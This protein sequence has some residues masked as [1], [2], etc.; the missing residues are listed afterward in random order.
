MTK[1][2]KQYEGWISNQERIKDAMPKFFMTG[3]SPPQELSFMEHIPVFKTKGEKNDWTYNGEDPDF[4]PP[5]KVRVTVTIEEVEHDKDILDA[6][7]IPAA[8]RTT[9]EVEQE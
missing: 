9:A 2:T 3:D 4:W 7:K 1:V 5:K 6:E 8:L